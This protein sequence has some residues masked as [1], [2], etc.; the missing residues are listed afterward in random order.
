MH[1]LNENG[2]FMDSESYW[3]IVNCINRDEGVFIVSRP[4]E[5]WRFVTSGDKEE[6]NCNVTS[7]RV[8][9]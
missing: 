2:D 4:D 1:P 7:E 6:M 3:A 8:R 5:T 9:Y